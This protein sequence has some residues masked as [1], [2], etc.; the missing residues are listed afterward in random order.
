MTLEQEGGRWTGW[1][2]GTRGWEGRVGEQEGGRVG[3]GWKVDRV[4]W[5][6][7]VGRWMRWGG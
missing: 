6:K 7:R 4:G 5:G 2:G 3:W 1:G